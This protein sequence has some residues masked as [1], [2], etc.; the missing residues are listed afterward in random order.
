MPAYTELLVWKKSLTLAK[1]VFKATETF[2]RTQQYVLV[3]QMQRAAL[4]IVSN[5]AEGSR[6]TRKEL[7]NFLRIA[8][9]SASELEAQIILSSELGFLEKAGEDRLREDLGH[10][11]RLLNATLRSLHAF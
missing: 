2:P 4:S 9:G 7:I 3:A 11:L 10:V 1:A 6:R 5:I 8:F